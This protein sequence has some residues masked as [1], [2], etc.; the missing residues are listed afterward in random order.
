VLYFPKNG[1]LMN[2]PELDQI[3]NQW[4]VNAPEIDPTFKRVVWSR[5]AAENERLLPGVQYLVW[6]TNKLTF[7]YVAIPAG[8]AAL[9]ITAGL[10]TFHGHQAAEQLSHELAQGYRQSINP[11]DMVK[12][13]RFRL[14][15]G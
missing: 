13:P 6:L 9:A 7:P 15:G 2:D 3:L 1:E 11:I 5:I 4:E 12:F 14:E 10:A 8:V